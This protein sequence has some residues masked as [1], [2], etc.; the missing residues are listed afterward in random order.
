MT[1]T[2]QIRLNRQGESQWKE[3]PTKWKGKAL[4]VH[5]PVVDGELSKEWCYWTITHIETGISA[6]TLNAPIN[7]VR[8]LSVAWDNAFSSIHKQEDV[9]DWPYTQEWRDQSNGFSPIVAPDSVEGII[10]RYAS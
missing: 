4:A 2:I 6:A 1:N 8:K 7:F 10:K 3:V 9:E 5:R